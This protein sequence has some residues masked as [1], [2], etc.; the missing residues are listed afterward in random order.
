MLHLL[1]QYKALLH[2]K[3]PQELEKDHLHSAAKQYLAAGYWS[4]MPVAA[5]GAKRV[6]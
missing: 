1:C 4:S 2:H 6:Q 3:V 5:G